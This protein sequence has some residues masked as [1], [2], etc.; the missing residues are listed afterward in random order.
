MFNW[1]ILNESPIACAPEA[2]A[3]TVEWL[4]PLKLYLIETCPE[5]KFIRLEWIKKWLI[6]LAP[7]FSNKIKSCC[8]PNV[9]K[10]GDYIFDS[11][12]EPKL[13]IASTIHP[14]SDHYPVDTILN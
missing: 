6:F 3:V 14:A 4:G 12:T 7:I 5:A 13:K 8:Y 11:E 1:I 9:H 10:P 2:H